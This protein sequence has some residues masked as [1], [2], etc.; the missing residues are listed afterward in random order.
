MEYSAQGFPSANET[1]FSNKA[2]GFVQATLGLSLL[3][4]ID[5]SSDHNGDGVISSD[6][7]NAKA[8]IPGLVAG[9]AF[10][11]VF[12][13]NGV[14]LEVSY[15]LSGIEYDQDVNLNGLSNSSESTNG[16]GLMN[17]NIGYVRYFL[18]GPYHIYLGT[19]PGF[20]MV[21]G[22]NHSNFQDE[23]DK[24]SS[25]RFNNFV[26]A[27]N[28]GFF[29]DVMAGGLGLELRAE[30]SILQSELSFDDPY[31][32]VDY[33]YTHPIQIKLMAVFLLGGI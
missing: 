18:E 19:I 10:I 17:F 23:K 20:Q 5:I 4:Y 3:P 9:L 11:P 31:G 24:S 7:R 1:P 29:K 6:I 22:R 21:M 14:L 13:D 28:F 30:Y 32:K 16:L 8:N 33:L 2:K 26:A 12:S 27:L 25:D 15:S